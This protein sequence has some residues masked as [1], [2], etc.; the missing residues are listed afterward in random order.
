[1]QFLPPSIEGYVP[2]DDPVRA[3]D[4]FVEKLDWRSLGLV[5]QEH[6]AGGPPS[7]PAVMLKILVYGYSY[8]I[9]SSRKL[10]RALHHNL[11]FIWRAGGLQPDFKT[12]SNFR[13]RNR[14]ALAQGLKQ[15]AR[16]CLKLDLIAGNTL[17]VDG[18]KLRANAGLKNRCTAASCAERLQQVDQRVETLLQE[19]ES[20]DAQAAQEDSLVHLQAEWAGQQSRKERIEAAVKQLQAE[21][22]PRVNTTDPDCTCVR[23]RQGCHAGYS[24]QIVVDDQHGLIVSADVVRENHDRQQ[25]APQLQAAQAITGKVP[26]VAVADGGYHS[27][28]ELEKMAAAATTVLVPARAPAGAAQGKAFAKGHFTYHADADVYVCP[29]GQRLPYRR[30]CADRGRREYSCDGGTCRACEH[31][32]ACTRGRNGRKIVRY[33]HEDLRDRLRQQFEEPAQREIYRRRKQKVEL[34]FGHFK[35]NLGADHFLWRG[36][37]GVRAEMALLASCFNVARLLGLFGVGG[38]RAKLSAL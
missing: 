10:E 27:G 5:A 33:L 19:C 6:Q 2:A 11:S 37:A 29:A 9:R 15:C 14:A 26:E 36:L 1:L 3:Y 18:S 32:Q 22:L 34:P 21:S 28:K 30:T 35:R 38:L 24:G 4:L 16:L 20:V 31:Y 7:P 23:G 17:F 13:R 8:G 12:I 25:L